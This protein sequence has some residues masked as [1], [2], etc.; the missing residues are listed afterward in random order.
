M[1]YTQYN[2][3]AVG[4]ERD[5]ILVATSPNLRPGSWTQRGDI[6]LSIAFSKHSRIDANLILNPPSNLS[7]YARGLFGMR[8]ASAMNLICA[9]AS[10]PS[11]PGPTDLNRTEGAFQYKNEDYFY[12]FYAKGNCCPAS[13]A[14]EED[15]YHV[16]VSRSILV[17]RPY[18]SKG[19]LRCDTVEGGGGTQIL[20]RSADRIVYSPCGVGVFDD[21]G[22]H[23]CWSAGAPY[24]PESP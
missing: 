6:G 1:Y 20:A 7:S 12:F 18:M 22:A 4:G 5:T 2:T 14:P 10:L 24:E 21:V 15:V 3:S 11:N 8:M 19:G 23:L 16:E 9:E 13:N 17:T